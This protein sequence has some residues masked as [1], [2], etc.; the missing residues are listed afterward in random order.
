MVGFGGRDEDIG[1]GDIMIFG[2]WAVGVGA[3]AFGGE[4]GLDSWRTVGVDDPIVVA[5]SKGVK[6]AVVLV[7][8]NE[9]RRGKVCE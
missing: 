4:R 3:E 2:G 6:M 5:V 1:G 8:G 9:G 7:D